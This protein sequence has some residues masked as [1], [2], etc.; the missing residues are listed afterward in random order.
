[1]ASSDDGK[2]LASGHSGG[3]RFGKVPALGNENK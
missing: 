3:L 1:M 2:L